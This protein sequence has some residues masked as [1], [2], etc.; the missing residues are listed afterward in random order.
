MRENEAR[1]EVGLSLFLLT[2]SEERLDREVTYND[3]YLNDVKIEGT[4]R[5]EI[6]STDENGSKTMRTTLND[7]KMTYEDGTFRTKRLK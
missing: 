5:T 6:L 2:N 1:Q 4:R 3:F 7:G